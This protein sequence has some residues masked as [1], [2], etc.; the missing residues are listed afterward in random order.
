MLAQIAYLHA[1]C[2]SAPTKPEQFWQK[3]SLCPIDSG[4][5]SGQKA[6]V[7]LRSLAQNEH[8][9]LYMFVCVCVCVANE[10]A[11]QHVRRVR[12]C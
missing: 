1:P 6:Q 2:L 11:G 10:L 7:E 12:M 9:S 5:L 4:G 8:I 3:V